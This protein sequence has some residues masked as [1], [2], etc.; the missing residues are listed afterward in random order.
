MTKQG[1]RGQSEGSP[2]RT[3]EPDSGAREKFRRIAA[4][5]AAAPGVELGAGRGFGSGALKVNGKLFALISSGGQFVA[6]LPKQRVAELVGLGAGK[7]FEPRPG[8]LM[9]E[10]I[11]LEGNHRRWADL[12]AEAHRHVGRIAG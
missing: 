8:R 12:A 11:A 10:W 9:K 3:P 2:P 7:C 1:K 5:F 6:K 4:Q